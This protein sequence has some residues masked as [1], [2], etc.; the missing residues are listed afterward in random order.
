MGYFQITF[1]LFS[2]W[3]LVLKHLFGNEFNLHV[4]ENLQSHE[5][6]S[7]KT[8]FQNEAKGN[9]E[10]ASLCLTWI[11]RRKLLNSVSYER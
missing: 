6:M 5:R 11:R 9:S 4:N 10:M 7:T 2:K 8:R 1:C 3:A